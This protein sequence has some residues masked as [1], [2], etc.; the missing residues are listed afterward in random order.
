[1][2]NYVFVQ[3]LAGPPESRHGLLAWLLRS[4]ATLTL[5]I[6]PVLLLLFVQVQFLPYHF[7]PATNVQR[8]TL[9][10]DFLFLWTL[11]PAIR[12]G[13]AKVGWKLSK[14]WKRP[15]AAVGTMLA[16]LFSLVIATFPGEYM[17]DFLAGEPGSLPTTA[18]S[19]PGTSAGS[20]PAP[21]NRRIRAELASLRALLF[22][23]DVD[24]VSRR[25][26]SLFSN[27]LV[28]P[29]S[30][31]IDESKFDTQT[32]L[33]AVRGTLSLRGRNLIRA[34]L[35]NSDLRKVDFTGSDMRKVEFSRADLRGAKFGC[36]SGYDYGL[37]SGDHS[38]CADL[39]GAILTESQVMGSLF[40]GALLQD[41]NL[42]NILGDSVSLRGADME[43]VNLTNASLQ[44]AKINYA[45]LSS[46]TLGGAILNGAQMGNA[47]LFQTELVTAQMIGAD[48]DF[49]DFTKAELQFAH[50]Q[51]ASLESAN[52]SNA[53]LSHAHLQGA[54]LGGATIDNARFDGA[55][56]AS[57][58]V[59]D[60]SSPD[61]AHTWKLTAHDKD[62]SSNLYAQLVTFGCAR[63]GA[64][65]VVRGIVAQIVAAMP[66]SLSS[67]SS[68]VPVLQGRIADLGRFA[69]NLLAT[70]SNE[71]L[72]EGAKGLNATEKEQ[73]GSLKGDVE[74]ILQRALAK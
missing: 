27:T 33:D 26:T 70:F 18:S 1:M 6:A 4:I 48:L 46:A 2:P 57:T 64:P 45:D 47:I 66:Q 55:E 63:I 62:F 61:G 39:R 12:A 49:A 41:A 29:D 59:T 36:A 28:L 21:G 44:G 72:C 5:G 73:M 3:F 7:E 24:P 68:A 56:L 25:R 20:T 13:Q 53:T 60:I 65:N 67:S 17:Y 16:M 43:R 74:N 69:P 51:G 31:L 40:D 32:K 58:P 14:P 30:D 42:S 37:G 11:W 50:L 19:N 38:T 35:K 71:N 15:A 34:V 23:G 9:I 54:D 10:V 22:E 52:L 8:L